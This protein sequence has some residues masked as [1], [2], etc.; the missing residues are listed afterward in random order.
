MSFLFC[1]L[2]FAE[3]EL[4]SWRS[5]SSTG[6]LSMPSGP[7]T[8]EVPPLSLVPAKHTRSM[9]REEGQGEQ[10]SADL[11]WTYPPVARQVHLAQQES[12]CAAE[13]PPPWS[14]PGLLQGAGCLSA[15]LLFYSA[16]FFGLLFL[17]VTS[18]SSQPPSPD[19]ALPEGRDSSDRCAFIP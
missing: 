3:E 17:P 10:D 12:Q 6:C 8:Q 19:C 9:A 15:Y 18:S 11:L 13:T 1:S 7:L 4:A 16:L 2:L 14:L 5:F